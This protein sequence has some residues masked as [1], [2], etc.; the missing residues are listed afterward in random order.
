LVVE[1]GTLARRRR[2]FGFVPKGHRKKSLECG[3]RTM[4]LAFA[5]RIVVVVFIV[6]IAMVLVVVFSSSSS[7]SFD[8]SCAR[9]FGLLGRY[10]TTTQFFLSF[11][12]VFFPRNPFSLFYGKRHV[13]THPAAVFFFSRF[14]LSLS[15]LFFFSLFFY[16]DDVIGRRA[17]F[18]LYS[19]DERLFGITTN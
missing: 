19:Y 13:I 5:P 7:S 12:L 14:F 8:S 3:V 16:T 15:L 2:V 17:Y 10:I 9:R 11:V 1:A 18:F 4:P 6:V